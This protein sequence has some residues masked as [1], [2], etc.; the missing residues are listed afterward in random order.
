MPGSADAALQWS[1]R[2]P[3]GLRRRMSPPGPETCATGRHDEVRV[4]NRVE[5][6]RMCVRA[7]QRERKGAGSAAVAAWLVRALTLE[8]GRSRVGDLVR[9]GGDLP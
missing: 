9:H 6:D 2:N 8:H 7:D 1:E 5:E 4:W 3:R